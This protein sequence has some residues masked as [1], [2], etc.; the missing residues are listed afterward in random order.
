MVD[1]VKNISTSNYQDNTNRN[2][3]IATVVGAAGGYLAGAKTKKIYKNGEF[4]DEFIKQLSDTMIDNLVKNKEVDAE[5]AKRAKEAL[6]LGENPDI[7]KVKEYFKKYAKS[8]EEYEGEIDDILK[9]TDAE[10]LAEFEELRS[11]LTS[12]IKNAKGLI[13]PV[14]EEHHTFNYKSDSKSG[15]V[16]FAQKAERALRRKAGAIWGVAAGVVLG[17]GTYI[18]SKVLNKNKAE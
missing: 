9:K 1:A 18:L 11:P 10:I 15:A 12:R 17:F 7:N 14:Y 2:T 5:R 6:A 8:I 16:L 13:R 4:T 3:G